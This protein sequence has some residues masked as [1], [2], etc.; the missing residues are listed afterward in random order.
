MMAQSAAG[1][2]AGSGTALAID[3][4]TDL[5]FSENELN[6]LLPF[7]QL[8]HLAIRPTDSWS[9]VVDLLAKGPLN[10]SEPGPIGI[11][12]IGNIPI[13]NIN[14]ISKK[15]ENALSNRDLIVSTD[16][17]NTSSCATRLLLTAPGVITRTELSKFKQKI[18][19]QSSPV[20]GWV[21]LDPELELG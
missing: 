2:V 5:I 17:R 11:V 7:P 13:E 9:D 12:P 8:D 10:V 3:R 18:A 21:L 16:L 14:L 19:L 4:R 6:T 20:A 15:L 1:L